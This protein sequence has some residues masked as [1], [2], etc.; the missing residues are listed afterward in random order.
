LAEAVLINSLRRAGNKLGERLYYLHGNLLS[1]I[2]V[3]H[4]SIPGSWH[5]AKR[6][7]LERCVDLY[8]NALATAGIHTNLSIPEPLLEWDFVHLSATENVYDN[9]TPIQLDDYKNSIYVRGTR[10]LRAF[11]SLF[12]A[13]SA[14]TPFQPVI[15]D[16]KQKVILTSNDSVRNLTFPNPLALDVP[17]LYRSYEDYLNKSYDLVRRGIR[18]G[19]NNW[20]PVRAR[21]FAEPVERL[22]AT[23]SDQ[24][25]DLYALGLYPEE[26]TNKVEDMA[27]QI[28]V[29]NLLAR[30]NLPMARVEIRTDEGGHSFEIDLANLTFKYLLF[31]RCYAD[32]EFA[33][34]FRYDEEDIE[35]ARRNEAISARQGL[36]AE[37]ENPLTGKPVQI[38]EFLSWSLNE[39]KQVAIG[40]GFW[41]NLVP[42]VEMVHGA[43]NTAEKLRNRLC[44]KI[45][46]NEEVP[47]EI[48]K[49]LAV[50]REMDVLHDV[51]MITSSFSLLGNEAGKINELIQK[52]REGFGQDYDLPIHFQPKSKI[53]VDTKY[54]D[55][56]SEILDL[57]QQMIKIPS[58]TACPDER[59]DQVKWAAGFI[60]DYAHN[61]GLSVRYFDQGKYPALLI[62]F[63][64]HERTPVMFSGHFD[65][66]APEPDDGQFV[67]R[68]EGDYLWGRGS[69]DMKTVVA[70]YLVWLKDMLR[71]GPPYSHLNLL[72]IGNEEN[73]EFEPMGTS[74]VLHLLNTESSYSPE[75]LIAGERTGERGDEMWGEICTRNRGVVRFDIIAR[76]QRKHTGTA[77]SG[78]II[79]SLTEKLLHAREA[80]D[81]ILVSHLTMTSQDGWQSQ[82]SY[83]FF[84][85]G[86]AGVYNVTPDFGSFGVEI[87]PIPEDRVDPLMV[88]VQNYCAEHELELIIVVK[89]NGI[90]CDPQNPY[91]IKLIK[92][93]GMISATDPVIG[94][95]LPGTSARFAPQGQ[96]IVWGQSGIGPHSKDE[97]HYIPSILPYYQVLTKFAELL[98]EGK[99]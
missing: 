37:I 67:P 46:L 53:D 14:S 3:D 76:G 18:F 2:R 78:M 66:V 21:S 22:I 27:K 95:K 88:Q 13:A 72:L 48:L 86:T 15:R 9:H 34:N 17:N 30:I 85:I 89:E 69:A 73:G 97:R 1:N 12:I 83:P 56:T 42:L 93:V 94:K 96:G 7:Y 68:V 62:G 74:H 44:S 92:S 24:L 63:P 79:N 52:A 10:L 4:D 36:R 64:E 28:E 57:A 26:Q 41:D 43:P 61:A 84:N 60:F 38:R 59:I 87:R 91:L 47:L 8:G 81:R 65:V 90:A 58:V 99:I 25:Q 70:T 35:R 6:R 40:L 11:A 51:D 49:E 20:T 50:E 45:N 75:L 31:L 29:Q 71:K 39:V 55:T 98:S 33:R 82:V 32:K 77:K 5:I 23:T 16:G 54:P 80:V 19:N